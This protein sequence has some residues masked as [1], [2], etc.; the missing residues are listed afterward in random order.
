MASSGSNVTRMAPRRVTAPADRRPSYAI[1]HHG[2][3]VG[4]VRPMTGLAVRGGQRWYWEIIMPTAIRNGGARTLEN[5][6][7]AAAA[8]GQWYSKPRTFG[9][10]LAEPEA[11]VGV[12]F[13]R[14]PAE[15][16]V[17]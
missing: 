7:N 9:E 3:E 5:A 14:R 15:K 6:R 8:A 4:A 12:T 10:I 2:Q 17:A 16:A 1:R 13:E 11:P